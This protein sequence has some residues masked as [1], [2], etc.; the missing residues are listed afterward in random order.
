MWD[1]VSA[2]RSV[3]TRP[4]QAQQALQI[5][6]RL[7]AVILL[8]GDAGLRS[9]EI[10]AL[11]PYGVKWDTKQLHIDR[12]VWRDVVDSPKSGRGRIIPMTDRV[13]WALRKLG[14]VKGESLLLDDDGTCFS[15]KR[16]RTLVKR[17]QREAGLEATGNVH[18]LR[19]TFC[20][21]L[22]MAG[23]PP[24][25]IQELAGHRHLST[26]MRYM[27]VVTGAK[28]DAIATLNRPL[29]TGLAPE[30]APETAS[31]F[32]RILAGDRGQEETPGRNRGLDGAGKGI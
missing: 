31:D 11:P 10:R 21:R 16:M 6:L 3:S 29:P 9:G 24:T 19:H 13:A 28:E 14:R 5:D 26:T 12:Q 4:D 23:K 30:E 18:I 27:H 2:F 20:T 1:T 25:V 15:T 7:A 17:A 8:G 22:A 32:G